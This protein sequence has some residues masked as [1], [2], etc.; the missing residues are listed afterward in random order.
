M[1]AAALRDALEDFLGAARFAKFKAAG[2]EPRMFYWQEREWD[3]FVEAH[4]QFA[5]AQ[6]ELAALLRFCLLHRQ[7]LL[8][9]R[10]EVVH[11]TVYYVR[12][13]AEP[14]A[15]RFP[16]SGLGPYYTQGA[17]HPD[18]THAVWYCPTCRELALAA[19]T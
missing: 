9:D 7:D 1:D 11:A 4:P 18:P 14:S 13:E 15:T 10:I 6:P 19:Q 5:P 2:F 17:P 16:H 8:P 3:R 12:D